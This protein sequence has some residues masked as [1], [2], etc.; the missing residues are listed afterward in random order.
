M[1]KNRMKSSKFNIYINKKSISVYDRSFNY[2]DGLFETILVRNNKAL[3]LNEHIIRLHTGCDKLFISKPSIKLIK[4]NV[5]Y[6]IGKNKNCVIKILVSRGSTFFG[7]QFPKKLKPNIYFFKINIKINPSLDKQ[8]IRLKYSK[9]IPDSDKNFSKIKHC[10]RLSQAIIANEL[11]KDKNITDLIVMKDDCIIETL[12]ANLFFVREQKKSYVFETPI[13]T[14]FGIDGVLK[15]K[16]SS[17][18]VKSKFK[19]TKKNIKASDLKKYISCF[20]VNS[21]KGIEFIDSIEKNKFNKPEILYNILKR[22]I[23]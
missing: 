21:I 23:Y 15:D 6:A 16:V 13:I 4:D 11:H 5:K 20:K 8:Q 7:Y 12:S 22:F 17:H 2:G 3:Y 19:V 18:L 9:F 1:I 10:N 14:D